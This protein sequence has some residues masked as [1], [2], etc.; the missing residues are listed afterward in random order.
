MRRFIAFGANVNAK[1]PGNWYIE[2]NYNNL[3]ESLVHHVIAYNRL[4]LLELFSANNYDFGF[5][6]KRLPAS[7]FG[8]VVPEA[9]SSST[10][11]AVEGCFPIHMKSHHSLI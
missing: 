11:R 1:D 6:T 2:Y 5:P 9:S 3:G 7:I 4:D 10:V 8:L